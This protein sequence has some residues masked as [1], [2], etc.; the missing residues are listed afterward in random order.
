MCISVSVKRDKNAVHSALV[1]LPFY[2]VDLYISFGQ[3]RMTEIDRI[4]G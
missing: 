1:A 2:I 3:L 4:N